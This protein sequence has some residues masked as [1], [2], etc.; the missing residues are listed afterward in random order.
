MKSPKAPDPYKTADAQTNSNLAT[1]QSQQA[2]NMVNQVTPYGNLD[3]SQN[4]TRQVWDGKKFINLPSYTATTTLSPEQ[5]RLYEQQSAFDIKS[6]DVAMGQLNRVGE[7]LGKGFNLN[8]EA[9]GKINE[10]QRSR[11]D[12]YWQQQEQ[13]FDSKMANQGVA[14]GSQA[15]TNARRTFDQG[16][17]DAYN[18]SYLSAR[19][20]GVNEALTQRNQPLNEA[21]ALAG[22]AG[23]TQPT[24]QN[25]PNTGVNG[26]DIAGLI[27]SNYQAKMQNYQANMGGLMNLGSTLAGGWMMSD[28]RAKTDIEKIGET[29]IKGVNAY[30]YR[31]KGSPLMQMG[32][33]A[34]EVEKKI[35]GAV[36]MGGDGFKRVNYSRVAESM[37]K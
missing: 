20:Q 28:K 14:A 25:T 31:Y 37:G 34:Q 35:P 32:V 26:T 2:L 15:Y 9:E 17:N 18:S 13:S 36:K 27:N 33:M 3:Y 5:R 30:K 8:S 11:L 24:F 23:V 29:P 19:Q 6:N 10:L 1:A 12:P 7:Q 21:L 16:R 4:G 22:Q